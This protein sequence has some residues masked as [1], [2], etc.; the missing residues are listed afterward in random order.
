VERF[1]LHQAIAGTA[2]DQSAVMDKINAADGVRMGW[3]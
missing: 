3:E 1:D 2:C